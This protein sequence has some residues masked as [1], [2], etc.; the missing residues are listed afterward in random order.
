MAKTI[1]LQSK[2]NTFRTFAVV[3]TLLNHVRAVPRNYQCD[4]FGDLCNNKRRIFT[5][6]SLGEILSIRFVALDIVHNECSV[7][8]KLTKF[9]FNL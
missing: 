3:L 4:G 6:R 1:Q 2:L 8:N 9:E 5:V 7:L